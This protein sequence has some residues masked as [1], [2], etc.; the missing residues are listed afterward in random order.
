MYL[1]R[2]VELAPC[3]ALVA[4][5]VHPYTEP[6]A[7]APVPDPT[8]VRLEVPVEGEGAKPHQ[9]AGRVCVPP[10]LPAR[11]RALPHRRVAMVP[12]SDGCVVACHVRTPG[13][14]VPAEPDAT[15]NLIQRGTVTGGEATA[16]ARLIG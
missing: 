8:Q 16:A 6:L 7:A 9:S 1:G 12:M 3:E 15:P 5:P 10:T 11:G 2:I 13:T 4:K 14:D